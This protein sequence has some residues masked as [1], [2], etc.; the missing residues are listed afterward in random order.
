MS[1]TGWPVYRTRVCVLTWHFFLFFFSSPWTPR[2]R[3]GKARNERERWGEFF[4][5]DVRNETGDAVPWAWTDAFGIG[6]QFSV[7]LIPVIT[8]ATTVAITS[9][10]SFCFFN[11]FPPFFNWRISNWHTCMHTN[12]QAF[13]CLENY[14]SKCYLS[15]SLVFYIVHW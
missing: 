3:I 4:R 14:I 2:W 7:S 8:S 9:F 6:E 15:E 12:V 13:R 11:F 10:F 1:T 5:V